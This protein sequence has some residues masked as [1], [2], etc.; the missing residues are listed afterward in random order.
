MKHNGKNIITDQD[1]TLT[2][3]GY[4]GQTLQDALSDQESRLDRVESNV[5]W[6]YRNGRVG[7]GSG[8]GSGSGSG[9]NWSAIITRTDNGAVLRDGA[10]LSLAGP[11]SYG[12]NV[13][14]YRGGSDVFRVQY[15]Y[16]TS[17]NTVNLSD[18]LNSNNSFTATR[19]LNLDINGVLTVKI[20]NTSEPEEAPLTF[21][22]PYVTSSYSFNLS[23]VY[24]NDHSPFIHSDN[25]IFMNDVK[26]RG[27]QAALTYSVAVGIQSASYTYTDWD[28]ITRTVSTGDNAIKEKSS[29][30]IYLDLCENI[31]EFLSDD[32]NGR[33]KQFLLDIDLTLEGQINPENIEQLSLKDNLIPSNLFLRVTASG[34]TI[35]DTRQASYSTSGQFIVGTIVFQVTPFYGPIVVGRTYNFSVFLDDIQLGENEGI[36]ITELTDQTLQS[37]PIPVSEA[38]E[39]KITFT[40]LEPRSGESYTVDYWFITREATSSFTYYPRRS[41]ST[42]TVDVSPQTTEVYRKLHECKDIDGLTPLSSITMSSVSTNPVVYNFGSGLLQTYDGLDQML[43]LGIQYVRTNDTSKPIAKF[44]I[45]NGPRGDVYIYQNKVLICADSVVS[46]DTINGDTCEIYLPMCKTLSDSNLE[47]YHLITIYKRFEKRES[48]NYWRG[49]YVYIDGILEGAFG[50]F[51]AAP[52]NKYSSLTLYPGNYYI[53]LIESSTFPHTDVKGDYDAFLYDIDIQGYYYAYKELLLGQTVDEESKQLFDNFK[54]FSADEDNFILTDQT[55]IYNIAK[56]SKAPVIIMNFTDQGNGINNIKGAGKDCFREY[57]STSYDENAEPERA[58]ITVEYSSGMSEPVIIQ[59]DGSPAVFSIEPQGSSTKGFRGKNWEMYAPAASEEDHVCIYSPNFKESDTTTFLP[60]ES[61][62]LKADIVDS[63]HTNNNAVAAFINDVTTGFTA[64][65]NAQKSPNT[66]DVS[67]YAGWVKN[68]LTGFPVLVFLHTNYR[69]SETVAELDVHRYYFLGIYNF[70]L[71]R[72]SYFNL[73]YKNTGVLENVN[74]LEGFNIY[75]IPRSANTLLPGIMVAEV[76]GNNEFFD[77]SQY[78]N[79]ILFKKSEGNDTTYMWGDFVSGTEEADTKTQVANFVKRV[80]K[81]GGYI[82]DSIGKNMSEDASKMYGYREGYSAVNESG[83]PLNQVPNYRAQA[84]RVVSGSDNVYNFSLT[85]EH[86]TVNDLQ[87]FI[88]SDPDDDDPTAVK[89]IDYDSLC[90][91]YTA[92][93]AFG[94][95]DSVEKNLN[96]KSWTFGREF[97]L[98]FYDMD[99]CLG[100]SNSGSKISYFA[101][102]DYWDWKNSID[103]GI[104]NSVKIYRDY[105][106]KEEG[107]DVSSSSFYDVPSSYL[108]AIAKYAYFVLRSTATSDDQVSSIAKH[109]NN[110]WARWRRSDGCLANAETF[111]DKYYRH[112]LE[113]IPE[114]AFNYNYRYKYFVRS[115]GNGFDAINFPK[116]YGRKVAYTETWLDNR[117]HILDAYFNINSINDLLTDRISAPMVTDNNI[118]DRTNKDIYVLHDIFSDSTVGAQY[119]NVNAAVTAKA[120]AYAPLIIQ[121]PNTSSRF[122]FPDNET[123]ECGFSVRTS[124]NQTVLFGGSAL[125]TEIS[126]INPFIT[127]SG[128][129]SITSDYFSSI[130]GTGGAYCSSWTFN[131]P[132]LKSLS[133]INGDDRTYYTGNITFSGVENY[134]NLSSVRVDGTGIYLTITNSNVMSVSALR[135]KSGSRL[136]I[137]NTPNISEIKVSGDVGDLTLPGWGTDIAIPYDGTEINSGEIT[138]NNLKYP[139]A[140]IT[141]SNAPNLQK[142]T[143]T[144]FASISIS[145]C[146]KL[147][148]IV[149]GDVEDQEN[150]GLRVLDIVMPAYNYNTAI[151]SFTIGGTTNVIDLSGWDY[152]EAIR[153]TN[154]YT[155]TSVILPDHEVKLY[156]SA[157]SG[158]SAL[159]YIAGDGRRTILS[160]DRDSLSASGD[161]NTF[162]DASDFTMRKSEGG[163]FVDLYV[164][165]NNTSLN[166]TFHINSD[167]KRGAISLEA[168]AKFLSEGC[169]DAGNVRTCDNLFRNQGIVYTRE[170]FVEEYNQGKCSLSLNKLP[171]CRSISNTFRGCAVDAISRYMFSGLNITSFSIP[172]TE[173]SWFSTTRSTN[174][175]TKTDPDTGAVAV[176]N[177]AIYTTSDVFED[178]IK[179]VRSITLLD[180]SQGVRLCV[181]DPNPDGTYT[182]KD[183]LRVAD[184]FNPSGKSPE[185]LLTLSYVE[186]FEGHKLDFTDTFSSNWAVAKVDGIGLTLSYFMYYGSYRYFAS[187][188]TLDGLFE[189]I[190]LASASFSFRDLSQYPGSVD[191]EHFINWSKIKICNNLFFSASGNFSLGFPKYCTYS[192]FHNIWY[193]IIKDFNFSKAGGTGGIGSIFHNCAIVSKSDIP[194]FTM[195]DEDQ[196]PDLVNTSA[197]NISYLFSG[198]VHKKSLQDSNTYGI[199]FTSDFLK[200]LP[201]I[202]IARYAFS[203]SKWANPVPFNF[204]RKQMERVDSVYVEKDGERVP[205]EFHT[206]SYKRELADISGCFSNVTMEE[207]ICYDP[208]ASYNTGTTRMYIRIPGD[209]TVYT[210]Y[211]TTTDPDELPTQIDDTGY[212]DCFGFT[213]GHPATTITF[214]NDVEWE[215][216]GYSGLSSGVFC[217]PDILYGVADGGVIEDLFNASGVP[218]KTPVFSGAIPKHMTRYLANNTPLSGI[219]NNLNIWPI[220]YGSVENAEDNVTLTYYY[221]VPSNFTQRANLGK[222]FNF[223]LLI[224]EKREV[225]SGGVYERPQ[226]YIFLN[227]SLPESLSSLDNA[228]PNASD[229][230]RTWAGNSEVEGS[231][232]SIMGTPVYSEDRLVGFT[233]GI[234]YEKYYNLK[235]DNIVLPGLAAIMSGDFIKGGGGSLLWNRKNQ[236][237]NIQN[238]AIILGVAG[239]STNAHMYLPLRNN[240]FL[241][242]T[243]NCLVSKSSVYNWENLS[244]DINPE[245]NTI[246][247]YESIVFVD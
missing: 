94:L 6:I 31:T 214:A 85:S 126:S 37:V 207:N 1:I 91:Y 153:L 168:A 130:M 52:H 109:P 7:T 164:S 212:T 187:P 190:K 108:F 172:V 239:L 154:L 125:W 232:Y 195:L 65:R 78:S 38:K 201:N 57:M 240:G 231:L 183:T 178:I 16:Q 138:V 118:V 66:G 191:M 197:T 146:P 142:L 171:S 215:N 101:F 245:T 53:N 150:F 216:P 12:I 223:K 51:V 203:G 56:Y 173:D 208:N 247:G 99:T 122:M 82:F 133:L 5:K 87:N 117:L 47:N 160:N 24:A 205:A 2:G 84:E 225:K 35:Y 41:V 40:V 238:S 67:R 39:H 18:T 185:N 83:I 143:L 44:G 180:S 181:I 69:S 33:Y 233:S 48:N 162:Y 116:F 64:A 105:S 9:S 230:G 174:I 224:P 186:F 218:K 144:G 226:Y 89:G 114:A 134:P 229:I 55:A 70:N 96:I 213:C 71:G 177:K 189:N 14:I 119:A 22:I 11:G 222:A 19:T 120:K 221:F 79:S 100:V 77:F 29:G 63:S 137:S 242:A 104:F 59:K 81:A 163:E 198:M 58:N 95:V 73:G 61:Y 241:S 21:S 206:F 235:F 199:H 179:D 156:P 110:I 145:G 98:A 237:A 148:S 236:L 157:F 194:V 135:M 68:C 209:D 97:Y 151:P 3:E 149:I 244:Q 20:S 147:T 8:G 23:Y 76:Q 132:G 86:A 211:Y 46:G 166:G 124:G 42:G 202:T 140:K 103:E 90:E 62:T 13:Q 32:T 141:I 161:S 131:T 188:T 228:L 123:T 169:I 128:S 220:L 34:G 15:T 217:A 25:T 4:A 92:C 30:T 17:T 219:F 49:I 184:L 112:H 175:E 27:L 136:A 129:F 111:I 227:D 80:S 234:D 200:H 158:C 93:M 45:T 196:Y 60:E 10:T 72:K 182:T 127:D 50:S 159:K 28:G 139:G 243:S 246:F 121:T 193:N 155:I 102:S 54:T 43:C 204:F 75:E 74:L 152:L 115:A 210:E 167:L 88:I 176:S 26:E 113:S 106:P 170:K 107:L 36:R 192:G 165:P